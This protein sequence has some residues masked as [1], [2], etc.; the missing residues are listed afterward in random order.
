[1]LLYNNTILI[2]INIPRDIYLIL[3]KLR[4]EIK[5]ILIIVNL[6]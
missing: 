2:I 4:L 5:K 1:M 6:L 3:K